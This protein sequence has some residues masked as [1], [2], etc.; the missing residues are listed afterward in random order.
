MIGG[1][2]VATVPIARLRDAYGPGVTRQRRPSTSIRPMG[3]NGPS[4]TTGD[5]A[6]LAQYRN[7]ARFLFSILAAL[8]AI[9]LVLVPA[10]TGGLDP[11]RFAAAW[12]LV[13]ILTVNVAATLL[14]LLSLIGGLSRWSAWALHAVVPVCFVLIVIGG[15]RTLL[16]LTQNQIQLPLEAIGGLLVLQPPARSRHQAAGH[17]RRPA[18]QHDRDRRAVRELLR[19][20]GP[21]ARLRHLT[22]LTWQARTSV[23]L[24][25][26]VV[27]GLRERREPTTLA[28]D[29]LVDPTFRDVI[30]P[31]VGVA[32]R[33]TG[34]AFV[35]RQVGD[36]RVRVV[37]DARIAEVDQPGR[38]G[39]AE[40]VDDVGRHP[41][42]RDRPKGVEV[43]TSGSST[44]QPASPCQA[45]SQHGV[46]ARGRAP[47]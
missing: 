47:R 13:V 6:A 46:A 21:A 27:G 30:A 1:I 26:G 23:E 5:L 3:A 18:A 35:R 25:R 28:R 12:P 15:T 10:S 40:V 14:V 8:A 41:V 4:S 9:G 19:P 38:D 17:D 44:G 34:R 39:R 22:T 32:G 43:P 42:G 16:A 20:A 7:W 11:D 29:V 31:L 33:R 24:D 45:G 37:G 2:A 36:G